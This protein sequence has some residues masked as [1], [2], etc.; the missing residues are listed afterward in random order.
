[1]KRLVVPEICKRKVVLGPPLWSSGQ[2][3]WLQIQRSGFGSRHYQ[4]FFEVV[5]LEH[6]PLRLVSTIEKLLGRISCIVASCCTRLT[7]NIK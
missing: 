2:S 6:G 3:S 4:I 5:G 7:F 1:M